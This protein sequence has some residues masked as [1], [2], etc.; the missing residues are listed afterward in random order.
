M[1]S[2]KLAN[3]RYC[4]VKTESFDTA[5]AGLEFT[6]SLG[7]LPTQGPLASAFRVKG[8]QAFMATFVTKLVPEKTDQLFI[9]RVN[10]S[11]D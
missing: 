7:L 4:F 11:D 6:C 10:Y 8:L 9:H 5:Q 3:S 1:Y 2:R